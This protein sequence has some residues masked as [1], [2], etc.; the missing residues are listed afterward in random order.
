MERQVPRPSA[1]KRAS[2]RRWTASRSAKPQPIS[3]ATRR[4]ATSAPRPGRTHPA[5]RLPSACSPSSTRRTGHDG[6]LPCGDS[7]RGV[8]MHRHKYTPVG[9]EHYTARDGPNLTV[10]LWRC[11]CGKVK[12]QHL[13]AFW[14]LEQVRHGTSAHLLLLTEKAS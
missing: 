12:T 9:V 14:P 8:V 13:A 7:G 3:C 10:V 1:V 4:H 2:A 11:R 6:G 5:A